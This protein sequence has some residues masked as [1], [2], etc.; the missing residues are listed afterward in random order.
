M[1]EFIIFHEYWTQNTIMSAVYISFYCLSLS[2]WYASV[3]LLLLFNFTEKMF[4]IQLRFRLFDEINF[5]FVL[6][7]QWHMKRM[8]IDLCSP[9]CNDC[10]ELIWNRKKKQEESETIIHLELNHKY[11]HC[12]QHIFFLACLISIKIK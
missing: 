9:W 7:T 6:F 5:F 8:S 10:V 3:E 4:Q 2:L 11:C 12:F 1:P